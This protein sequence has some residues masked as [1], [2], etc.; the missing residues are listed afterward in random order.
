MGLSM[1]TKLA[2]RRSTSFWMG[3]WFLATAIGNKLSG[4]IGIFWK[5]WPHHLF[6]TM[7]AVSSLMAAIAI[8][9]QLRRLNKAMPKEGDQ[10]PVRTKNRRTSLKVATV[11]TN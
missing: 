6:F 5:L 11:S 7:L 10:E 4:E 2:P 1:V 3:I 9:V 8:V